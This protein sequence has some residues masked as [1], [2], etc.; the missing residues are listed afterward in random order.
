M[1]MG[2]LVVGVESR[3][4]SLEIDSEIPDL[5]RGARGSVERDAY[6][7]RQSFLNSSTTCS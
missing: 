6:A 7:K 3:S 2:W 4:Q 5:H 1:W